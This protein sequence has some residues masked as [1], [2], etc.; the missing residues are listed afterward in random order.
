MQDT[1]FRPAFGTRPDRIVGRDAIIGTFVDGLADRVGARDRATLFLGQRGMGKTALLLDMEERAR[2][3]DFVPVRVTASETMLEEIV[4]T[5]QIEG[6][7]I[8]GRDRHRL[9]GLSANAFGFGVGLTFERSVRENYGFRVKLSLLL[10]RLAEAG[11]GILLL[12]DEV[13]STGPEM[14]TLATTYQHLVGEEKNIAI[15]MAGLPAA[16]SDVLNDEV[17]TFLNRAR[18]VRLGP[19]PVPEVEAYY[20]EVFERLSLNAHPV[21]LR[22]IAKATRGFPYLLQLVGHY[23][24]LYE[25]DGAIEEDVADMAVRSALEDLEETVFRPA[26]APLSSKDREFLRA[27]AEDEGPSQVDAIKERMGV[28]A[29]YVQTY[30]RRL[31]DAGTVVPIARGTLDIAIPYLKEHLRNEL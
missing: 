22:S 1:I 3:L 21:T 4:E 7:L 19:V 5:V 13:R 14:R 18:Q 11:L 16:I 8:L 31:I 30:R 12:V 20:A 6:E 27:M 28:S 17:L 24:L 26:L 2:V 25:R 15:A 10:D 23:L 9:S 29:K